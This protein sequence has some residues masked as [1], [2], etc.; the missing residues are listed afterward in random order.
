MFLKACAEHCASLARSRRWAECENVAGRWLD[1]EPL[2]AD[3]AIYYLNA[4]KSPGTRAALAKAL[5]EFEALRTRLNH[6]FELAPHPS[7]VELSTRIREQLANAPP[8]PVVNVRVTAETKIE[9]LPLPPAIPADAP[10]LKS[11]PS[12]AAPAPR[13]RGL[14][15]VGLVLALAAITIA[16][17]MAGDDKE[18]VITKPVIAV[19]SLPMRGSDSA[20]RSEERRVGKECRS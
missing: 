15:V 8:E 13:S 12:A 7:V 2:S 3:A 1:T 5:E 11:P 19:L 6:E 16:I 9:P 18:S 4:I 14:A 17:S 10:A 20:S